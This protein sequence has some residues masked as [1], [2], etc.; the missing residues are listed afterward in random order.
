MSGNWHGHPTRVA[1]YGN[2]R[3]HRHIIVRADSQRV[4]TR[5]ASNGAFLVLLAPTTDPAAVTVTVDGRP[6]GP[7][8]GTVEP[9]EGAR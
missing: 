7:T 2:A 6:Y 8:H 5:P 1:V 4:Q 9:P 3:E